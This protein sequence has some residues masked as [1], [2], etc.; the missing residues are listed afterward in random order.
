MLRNNYTVIAIAGAERKIKEN[1]ST[2][3][4]H[5]KNKVF[6]KAFM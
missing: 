3:C 2:Y 5:K 1:G 4:V 6:K